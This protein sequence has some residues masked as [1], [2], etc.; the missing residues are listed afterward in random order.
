MGALGSPDGK[1]ENGQIRTAWT[2]GG[3][4]LGPYSRWYPGLLWMASSQALGATQLL[5]SLEIGISRTS[6]LGELGRWRP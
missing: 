3:G 4:D 1:A 6:A 5:G 2:G